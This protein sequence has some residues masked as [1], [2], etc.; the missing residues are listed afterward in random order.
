M[1]K[2][3]RR[4]YLREF[5]GDVGNPH[6]CANCQGDDL[7]DF[8]VRM[9]FQ[10]IVDTATRTVFAY[11]ALVRGM[12]GEGAGAVIARVRP[13]QLYR[14]DQTCRVKA[15]DTAA[16][17]GM[18]T[19][20]SINFNPNAVYEPS[21]CIRLTLAAAETGQRLRG[22]AGGATGPV[23]KGPMFCR[24]R[25][26]PSFSTRPPDFSNASMCAAICSLSIFLCRLSLVPAGGPLPA[27][28]LLPFFG[29]AIDVPWC[30]AAGSARRA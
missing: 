12:E 8:D 23:A 25:V 9:A 11:E 24:V 17:L 7:L 13:D 6:P 28:D 27:T 10:P 30:H 2:V 14:F 26:T 5:F 18:Q 1:H 16:R 29:V 21:T 22:L 4:M 20:L 19:R 3:A 15:I